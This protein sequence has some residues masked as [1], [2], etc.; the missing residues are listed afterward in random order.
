MTFFLFRA[1]SGLR[2]TLFLVAGTL[3]LAMALLA[4]G[5]T[6]VGGGFSSFATA[7]S[8]K[9]SKALHRRGPRRVMF[10]VFHCWRDGIE[11][12]CPERSSPLY[13]SKYVE[14]KLKTGGSFTRTQAISVLE[15]LKSRHTLKNRKIQRVVGSISSGWRL[16][17][18]V[19]DPPTMDPEE[20]RRHSKKQ[21]EYINM[22][23]FVADSE[24]GIPKR[25]PCGGRL[26][27]EVRGKED[28]DTLP[29]KRFFNCRNYDL[30]PQMSYTF[31]MSRNRL[32]H[33]MRRSM[34]SLCRSIPSRRSVSIDN[35]R[36]RVG[37]DSVAVTGWKFRLL[38]D[39]LSGRL[40]LFAVYS[41]KV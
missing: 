21:H 33:S 31:A 8:S 11:Q 7:K 12:A 9:A 24:Y 27:N 17:D 40:C 26:I 39:N 34:T 29:G 1:C 20:D 30:L 22:L 35:E 28:Y 2:A 14:G 41:R 38:R 13:Q 36:S 19:A 5:S 32:I 3:R 23:S 37:G 16:G 4:V 25:C 18:G 10:S 15:G 6:V